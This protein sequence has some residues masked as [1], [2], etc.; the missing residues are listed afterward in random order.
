MSTVS[1]Q[2]NDCL[3]YNWRGPQHLADVEKFK[4]GLRWNSFLKPKPYKHRI[5]WS[6]NVSRHITGSVKVVHCDG[7]KRK[8]NEI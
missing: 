1:S 2:I 6:S 7:Q 5:K 3:L 4:S 8:S